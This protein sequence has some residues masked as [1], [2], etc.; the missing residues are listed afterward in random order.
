MST[1]CIGIDEV[2]RGPV[3]GPVVVCVCALLGETSFLH[4]FPKSHLR[5]SKKLSQAARVHIAEALH[6]DTSSTVKFAISFVDAD[7]IDREG[8]S[9]AI[10]KA[11][12]EAL[13]KLH[14]QGVPQNSFIFL[15]GSLKA[16]KE[17]AQ[18]TIIKG[19]EKVEA[20]ALASI[21]AK[22]ARD[23]F[24]V[25]VAAKYPEYGFET[26]VGYGTA[27]H[28]VAIKQYGLTP[29]HRKSFLKKFLE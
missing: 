23:A 6:K 26:H 14:A 8:I 24:M 15:D 10:S 20:I 2:G 11:L 16:P 4:L 25:E 28:L 21:L 5:D 18:E 17:Y 1:Y 22:V 3:A 7:V 27:K 13:S 12:T 9:V 29:L 19:D